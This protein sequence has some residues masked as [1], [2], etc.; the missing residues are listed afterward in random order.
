MSAAETVLTPSS[1][2]VLTATAADRTEIFMVAP[3]K[4]IRNELEIN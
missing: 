3:T 2:L 4:T 1:V